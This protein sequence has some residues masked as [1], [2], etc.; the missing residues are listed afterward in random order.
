[1]EYIEKVLEKLREWARELIEA[2]LG[3]EPQPE[4]EPVPVPVRDFPRSR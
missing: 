4:A 1:M 2:L 3:P